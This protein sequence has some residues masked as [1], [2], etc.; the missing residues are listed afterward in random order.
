[1]SKLIFSRLTKHRDNNGLWQ[2]PIII[3]PPDY[4][5]ISS[6]FNDWADNMCFR[7]V[8]ALK[9]YPKWYLDSITECDE[10]FYAN[11]RENK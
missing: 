9:P 8:Q 11:L 10:G 1:M 4:V 6:N 7:V 2:V 3:E 5:P